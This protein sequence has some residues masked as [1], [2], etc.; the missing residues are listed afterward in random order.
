MVPVGYLD[1]DGFLFSVDRK[2]ELI[3]RSGEN[4]HPHVSASST[5]RGSIQVARNPRPGAALGKSGG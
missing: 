3:V 4:I 5:S 1:E 2:K